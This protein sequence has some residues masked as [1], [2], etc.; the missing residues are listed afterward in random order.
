MDRIPKMS[1]RNGIKLTNQMTVTRGGYSR[2]LECD[3][4]NPRIIPHYKLLDVVPL[5]EVT[6]AR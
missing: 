2:L 5:W 1:P 4:C 3:Q 6:G